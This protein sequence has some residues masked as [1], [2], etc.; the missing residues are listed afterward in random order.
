MS[1]IILATTIQII[2]NANM[3]Q[4]TYDYTDLINE[5]YNC[6]RA[7]AEEIDPN[8]IENLV[9]IE[10]AFFVENNI[11]D[12]L[13]GMLL[14]AACNES[15]YN[16]FAKGDYRTTRRGN[17]V[18]MARGILQFWPWATRRYGFDRADYQ[19]SAHFWMTHMVNLRERNLCPNRF[20]E[21]RKWIAA[22]TQTCRCLL[23]RENRYRCYQVTGHYRRLQRWQKRINDR[24][25]QEAN[26]PGC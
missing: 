9:R 14:V 26:E 17:R 8:I 23:S 19:L 3:Q 22:W 10:D 5:A 16:P 21:K 24:K 4:L 25:E 13:R 20:S 11:P 12:E 6:S 15:G 7:N 1:H 18:A 2:I